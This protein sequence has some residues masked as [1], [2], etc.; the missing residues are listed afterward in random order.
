MKFCSQPSEPHLTRYLVDNKAFSSHVV[1]DEIYPVWTY[2]YLP[3]LFISAPLAEFWGYKRVILLGTALRLGTRVL[4]LVG[5]GKVAMQLM[6]ALYAGGSVAEIVLSAYVFRVVSSQRYEEGVAASQSAY[7]ISHVLSGVVGDVMTEAIGWSLEST[8]WVALAAVAAAALVALVCFPSD[9]EC[10][11]E[12]PTSASRTQGLEMKTAA[13]ATAAEGEDAGPGREASPGLR[14]ASGAAPAAKA[15]APPSPASAAGASLGAAPSAT[16]QWRLSLRV[17]LLCLADARYLPLV[18]LW[19]AGNCAWLF[20][21][22]WETSLYAIWQ[23]DGSDWN[24]SVLG[25]GLVLAAAA[26]ALVTLAPIKRLVIARPFTVALV[27]AVLALAAA[28]GTAASPWPAGLLSLLAYMFGWQ[29]CNAAFLVATARQVDAVSA[30]IEEAANAEETAEEAA[31]GAVRDV[32]PE[33][34]PYSTLLLLLNGASLLLQTVLQ[35]WWLT[36]WGIGVLQL[37]FYSALALAGGIVV[38]SLARAACM[39]TVRAEREL[40]PESVPLCAGGSDP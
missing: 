19:A 22:G 17:V 12:E 4:L 26:S 14:S 18:L 6:E 32:A 37:C 39:G 5:S 10:T 9:Y 40:V 25:L 3:L 8:F 33:R 31:T 35:A 36:G 2:A 7:F 15:A 13:K 16:P 23:P 20:I 24:G 29:F 30:R 34:S 21:Y 27:V 11:Q 1:N 28:L 38:S